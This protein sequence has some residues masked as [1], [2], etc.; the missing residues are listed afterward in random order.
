MFL[1]QGEREVEIATES[2]GAASRSFSFLYAR[3]AC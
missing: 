2:V 3:F 1:E